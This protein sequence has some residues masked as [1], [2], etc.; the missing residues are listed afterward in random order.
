MQMYAGCPPKHAYW[1]HGMADD[2]AVPDN[3]SDVADLEPMEAF[4][5]A[6]QKMAS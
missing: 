4:F 6:R 3:L 1:A 2:L 5:A